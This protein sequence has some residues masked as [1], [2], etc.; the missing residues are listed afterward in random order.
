M[1]IIFQINGG[2]GKSVI[3]TAVCKAIKKQYPKADLIV[4]TGYPEVFMQNPN[5]SRVLS[6]NNLNYFYADNIE[7]QENN[8]MFLQDPY[9]DT[10]FIYQRGHL[11]EVWCKMNGIQYNG[12]LPE[13]FITGKEKTA[14]AP[15]F[16]SNK[17]IL[18]IQTNGGVPNQTDKYSWP[19]DLPI[20]TAQRIVNA[21]AH[22][23]NVVHIRRN[24]QLQLQN[25]YPVQ[26]EF[27]QLA[28]LLM[29]SSKRLFIDSFAQ[30]AA[31]A[32][33][34]SSVVCWIANV[35]SQ[36]GYAMHN[37]IIA[38][39]PTLK[40]ELRNAVFNKYNIMGQP[41]DFPYN[42]EDEIFDADAIITALRNN[43]PQL[44][45]QPQPVMAEPAD[46]KKKLKPE[47]ETV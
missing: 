30:H 8:L 47:L 39:Q 22:E 18:A 20:N 34:L 31:A 2:I 6:F 37:N 41:T 33:G 17:P 40:P 21:F 26:A 23:Y 29:M 11:A 44:Q 46:S 27:R 35:P 19:R 24:D 5:V 38:N 7:G 45:P 12:E 28:V 13:L 4:I 9:F 1:K 14:Y 25:T 42:S 16:A 43:G 36:F 15:L 32:L 10:D 3:A